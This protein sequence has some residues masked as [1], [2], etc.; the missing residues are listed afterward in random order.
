VRG[1]TPSDGGGLELALLDAPAVEVSRRR[2]PQFKTL[3]TI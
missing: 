1:V 3:S 2:A